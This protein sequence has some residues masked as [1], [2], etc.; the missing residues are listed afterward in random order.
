MEYRDYSDIRELVGDEQLQHMLYIDRDFDDLFGL[1]ADDFLT[2]DPSIRVP[3]FAEI[4]DYRGASVKGDPADRWIVKPLKDEDVLPAQMAAVC[5]FLDFYAHTLSAPIVTTRIGKTLYK[6]TKLIT[7][8]EQ[9]SGANYTEH[10][11]LKEQLLLDAVNRWIYFDEDRNPNNYMIVYNSK[12][13]EILVAID[14]ANVDLLAG[15]M[16]VK[17]T[18]R[19]FGWERKEKTRYLTPLKAEN[20]LEYDIG[21]FEQ[22]FGFFKKM[23]T[24][25]ITETCEAVLRYNPDRKKLSR[26]IAGNILARTD[27][28]HGYFTSH[29]GKSTTGK[30]AKQSKYREMGKT[31]ERMYG[32]TA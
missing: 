26:L 32:D 2:I 16:K 13:E 3:F 28:L 23:S 19:R 18:P 14:F 12:N 9:L 8:S 1:V 29:L 11:Q 15:E 10:R 5:F 31:F 25:L 7:R 21:F 22:R 24:R 4:R 20:F 27:Y 6:A 17:G 30:K